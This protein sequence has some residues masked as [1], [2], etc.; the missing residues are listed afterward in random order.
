[1]QYA[2]GQLKITSYRGRDSGLGE[3]LVVIGAVGHD[4]T[5]HLEQSFGD[6]GGSHG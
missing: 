1:M 5:A 3:V 2:G 6:I 4:M